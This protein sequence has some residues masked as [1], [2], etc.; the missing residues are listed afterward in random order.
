M[1]RI[2]SLSLPAVFSGLPDSCLKDGCTKAE[3]EGS[4]DGFFRLHALRLLLIILPHPAP[5]FGIFCVRRPRRP[6]SL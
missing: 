4:A 5:A 1:R 6:V 2:G 3:S